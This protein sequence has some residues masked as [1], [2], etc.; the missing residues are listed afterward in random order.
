MDSLFFCLFGF[1]GF[2]FFVK[3]SEM[4]A[5]FMLTIQMKKINTIYNKRT[6]LVSTILGR[7]WRERSSRF[8]LWAFV[9]IMIITIA[10][11]MKRINLS[12]RTWNRTQMPL[13]SRTKLFNPLGGL[14]Q[15]GNMANNN[16]TI[17]DKDKTTYPLI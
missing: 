17:L 9:G 15:K 4:Y 1:W 11:T 10:P 7:S 12:N 16:W 8:L 13:N 3:C 6:I 5:F 2:F 14:R